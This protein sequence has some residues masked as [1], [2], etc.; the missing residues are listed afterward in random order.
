M[1]AGGGAR[2][3]RNPRIRIRNTRRPS[4]A[5]E[6]FGASLAPLQ[7][8]IRVNQVPGVRSFLAH[9]RLISIAPPARAA[10]FRWQ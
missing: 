5:R 7:G 8:A 2:N 9:P 1:L 4:G 3:E 6:D 10:G